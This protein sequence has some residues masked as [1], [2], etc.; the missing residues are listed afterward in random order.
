MKYNDLAFKYMA[1]QKWV[2]I[3]WVVPY[4]VILIKCQLYRGIWGHAHQRSSLYHKL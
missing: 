4:Y 1:V 3:L 2:T